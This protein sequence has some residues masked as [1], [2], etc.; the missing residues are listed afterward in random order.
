ML[1]LHV[2]WIINPCVF[3]EIFGIDEIGRVF[4]DPLPWDPILFVPGCKTWK[5]SGQMSKVQFKSG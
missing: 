4:F 5:K 2:T 1:L 3:R